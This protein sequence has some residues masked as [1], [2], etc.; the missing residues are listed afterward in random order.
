MGSELIFTLLHWLQ[1]RGWKVGNPFFL[2]G[3]LSI[4]PHQQSYY[5]H[6]YIARN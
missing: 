3:L 5:A 6:R 1:Q 2:H 4:P